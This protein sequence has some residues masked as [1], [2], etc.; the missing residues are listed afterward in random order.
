[1]KILVAMSG[2]VDSSTIAHLLHEEGHELVGVMM[3]LWMDPLAPVV[4]RAIPT[5]CC[6]VEH[7]QRARS[8]CSTLG[9][10]FYLLN[11]EEEFKEFVVNPFLES[12]TKGGTPNPCIACNRHIKFGMLLQKAKEL[13]C[14]KIATGHYARILQDEKMQCHLH[15]ATDTEKDQSYYLYGLQQEAL[16]K[17]LFPLGNMH[18]ADVFALAKKY[19]ISVPETYRESQ[20]LCFFPEKNPDKFL[21]RYIP[22]IQPGDIVNEAGTKVGTHKGLPFYTIG[23][24]KGLGIGGLQIPLHVQRKDPQT[25]TIIVAPDGADAT[26][27][28]YVDD[29]RWIHEQPKDCS[30]IAARVSSLGTMYTGALCL[31]GKN[32]I[33]KFKQ[34]VRGIADDQAIVFYKK[35]EVLGGGSIRRL[36][37]ELSK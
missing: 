7:I 27:D 25:N 6:S 28:F 14:E 32:T 35:D 33:M 1:M 3:K 4:Q 31:Q 26:T 22:N 15:M 16:Q 24:R 11:L 10:P 8:V 17:I 5:K 2:G 18:K 36:D 37:T 21:E 12:Y 13:G 34:A 19:A 29:I 9:I 20:D 30:Q 23:Q